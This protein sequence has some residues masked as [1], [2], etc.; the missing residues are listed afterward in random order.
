MALTFAAI[1]L[2]SAIAGFFI[3]P[4]AGWLMVGTCA[5]LGLV[6]MLFTRARYRR[7][8]RL[9]EQVDQ[10]LHGGDRLA[11]DA[12]EEGELSILQSEIGKMTVRIRE[13]NA[14]LAREK[15]HLADSLADIAHQLRTPLTS[16]NLL[17]TLIAGEGD[18]SRRRATAREAEALLER[19]EWLLNGLLKLSRLDADIV[20]FSREPVEVD[21]LV[22]DA[23]R[24][25]LISMELHDIAVHADVPAGV[26]VM[27]DKPWLSEAL[28]NLFKN[29]IES[30][31][32]G[33]SIDI[34]CE[35]NP[36][37]TE[38]AVRDSGP[39][40][41]PEDLPHVFERFYRGK[42]EGASGYGIGLSLCRTI[43]TRQGGTVRVRNHPAGGAVFYVRF[44]K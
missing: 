12:V 35:D 34:T 27:G 33:G 42:R 25:F 7:I 31:G 23:L 14:A 19:M 44:P 36:L 13:Q 5:A 38:I 6:T 8:A 11:I 9:S 39:G 24:P 20:A 10:V 32:D 2:A 22:R 3:H 16:L 43:V 40:I 15:Q 41:D 21:A 18:A 17:T 26:T 37:F 30:A 28:Q 29:A 1:G 4:L